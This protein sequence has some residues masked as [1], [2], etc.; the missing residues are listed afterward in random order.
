MCDVRV[1]VLTHLSA[2]VMVTVP[3]PVG[4]WSE[5]CEQLVMKA[6]AEQWQRAK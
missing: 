2:G 3:N 6:C 1:E 5:E 4:L